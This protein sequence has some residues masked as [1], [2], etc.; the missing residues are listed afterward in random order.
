[1]VVSN[2][3]TAQLYQKERQR[4]LTELKKRYTLHTVHCSVLSTLPLTTYHPTTHYSLLTSSLLTTYYSLLSTH[5]LLLTTHYTHYTHYSLLTTR[6]SL[7]T[8]HYLLLATHWLLL[9]GYYSLVTT[10][11]SRSRRRRIDGRC[12][13]SQRKR[14]SSSR[15]EQSRKQTSFSQ[16]PEQV[17][18]SKWQVVGSK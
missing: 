2:Q 6:Y 18:S 17:A 8:T 7:L 14:G 10:H 13:G 4:R 5:W 16:A 3:S 9:T 12:K 11:T 1:M 15:Y